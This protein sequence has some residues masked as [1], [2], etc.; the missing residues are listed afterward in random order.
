MKYKILLTGKDGAM[1]DDFFSQMTDRFEMV[2]TSV[3]FTD[4]V[5]HI[6]FFKPDI[7][8]CCLQNESPDDLALLTNIK[9]RLAHSDVP[10][11]ITG[12]K[13]YCDAFEKLDDTPVNLTL[14]KPLSIAIVQDKLITLVRDSRFRQ[15]V[16]EI[17]EE[18]ASKARAA[19][20]EQSAASGTSSAAGQSA[21]PRTIPTAKQP[22]ASGVT[23]AN[24]Q[25]DA[26]RTGLAAGSSA[27]SQTVP[28]AESQQRKHVLVVDDN[29]MMLKMIKEHLH[30]QYDVAT[31]ASGRVALKFLERKKTDLILLD[32]EM[33]DESGPAVLEKLRASETTKN[34]P[35]IF[36]TGVTDTNKIMEAL[37]LKPQNYLLKPVD[38]EKLLDIIAKTIG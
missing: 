36:L 28:G 3:R 15:T 30:D 9:Y 2:T 31:A 27:A 35:V 6:A 19:A 16:D 8:I 11:V 10:M 1:I 13:E 7:F 24:G 25:S 12:L 17:S 34:I 14:R 37:A 29:A 5:N 20:A 18:N 22:A 26:P 4:I 32:Y 33:P 38:R 23:P 21:V